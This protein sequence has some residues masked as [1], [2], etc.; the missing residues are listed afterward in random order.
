MGIDT[1]GVRR[2]SNA[3]KSSWQMQLLESDQLQ[4]E[5]ARGGRARWSI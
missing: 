1:T 4:V 3:G 2:E 5:T